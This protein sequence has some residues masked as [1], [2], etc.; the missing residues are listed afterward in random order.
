[1]YF[2]VSN[3]YLSNIGIVT[4]SVEVTNN[5]LLEFSFPGALVRS[6]AAKIIEQ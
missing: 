5:I 3:G 1:M 4:G 6:F 2:N